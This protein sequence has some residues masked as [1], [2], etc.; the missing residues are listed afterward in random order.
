MSDLSDLLNERIN[1]TRQMWELD[2]PPDATIPNTAV[3]L[4]SSQNAMNVI[5]IPTVGP[6]LLHLE[7]QMFVDG[8][9]AEP[10]TRWSEETPG[11]LEITLRRPTQ[12]T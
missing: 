8:E 11:V 12:E 7:M 4:A 10:E 5:V 2:F 1:P 6:G 9:H 3:M